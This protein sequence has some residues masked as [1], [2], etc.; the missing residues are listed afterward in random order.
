MQ[1]RRVKLEVNEWKTECLVVVRNGQHVEPLEVDG[2]RFGGVAEFRYLDID[3]ERGSPEAR[4][5]V[6]DRRSGR[7]ARAPVGRTRSAGAA[8][9]RREACRDGAARRKT[10]DAAVVLRAL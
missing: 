2:P 9:S 3:Q 8:G 4:R 10:G 6:L 1:A 5:P 7:V